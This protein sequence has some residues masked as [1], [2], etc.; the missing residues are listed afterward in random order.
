MAEHP[1]DYDFIMNPGSNQ[2]AKRPLLPTGNSTKQRLLIVA[3]GAVILLLIVIIVFAL[4]ASAGNA[5]KA[6][7][8]KAAQQ[9]AEIIRISK[10]GIDKARDT[11]AKNLA[12]TANLSMQ[13]D[14]TILLAALKNQGIKLSPAEL[15]GGKDSKT[16]AT[17]TSAE[18]SNRF[19][20]TFTQ[21]M[22]TMLAEY[23]KVLKTAFDGTDNAKLQQTLSAQFEHAGLLATAK[24]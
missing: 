3:G 16:D 5:G 14:Q 20:E 24:Q 9:Q 17:L 6:N 12:T 19:D 22:Q 2:P 10:L 21:T 18:Q 11:S 8:M 23:Q 15:A 7:L 1:S 4:F 13:S